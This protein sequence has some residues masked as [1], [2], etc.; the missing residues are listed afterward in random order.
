MKKTNSDVHFCHSRA[1]KVP[2]KEV[3]PKPMS[4][5]SPPMAPKNAPFSRFH[6]WQKCHPSKI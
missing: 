4:A 5:L 3:D 2:L 6:E 1:V